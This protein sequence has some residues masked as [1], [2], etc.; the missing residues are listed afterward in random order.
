M[1]GRELIAIGLG[2]QPAA[3]DAQQRVVRLVIVGAREIWLV[4]RNQRQ[5]F[6]IGEIDQPGFDA[7]LPVDA[8]ALQLDIEAV[9]EQARQPLAARRRKRVIDRR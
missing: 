9:A 7:P 2:D 6:G 3:G 8:V 5:S 4:G 1:I